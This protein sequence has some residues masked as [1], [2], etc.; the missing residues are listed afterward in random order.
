ML[1][2]EKLTNELD[3]NQVDEV[4]AGKEANTWWDLWTT[5]GGTSGVNDGCL[6]RTTDYCD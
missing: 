2:L 6:T 1:T 4:I 5:A 3:F